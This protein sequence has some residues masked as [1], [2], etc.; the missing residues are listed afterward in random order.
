MN[1]NKGTPIRVLTRPQSSPTLNS[2][3]SKVNSIPPIPSE[4]QRIGLRPS[5]PDKVVVVGFIGER[6]DD[7][8]QLMNRILDANVFGSGKM[9]RSLVDGD[10]CEVSEEL[11]RWLKWHRVRYFHEVE[12][13][14]LFLQF[15]S[16]ELLDLVDED[17][18]FETAVEDWEVGNL[19]GMLLMFSVSLGFAAHSGN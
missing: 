1:A 10:V 16:V 3:L 17:V 18:E 5:F 9:D 8:T 6:S 15:A 14:I 12:K 7:V 4:P 11:K 13:G 19:Q 2:P